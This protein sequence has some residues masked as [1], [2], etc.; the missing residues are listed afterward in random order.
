MPER[1][2]KMIMETG[3]TEKVG[4]SHHKIL[5]DI[6]IDAAPDIVW[7]VLTDTANY[8]DWAA[9]LVA[10]EGQIEDGATITAVFHTDPAKDNLTRIDHKITVLDGEAFY[11]AE[12]GPG[13][14][15]DNHHFRVE[16]NED[17]QTRFTQSDEIM[18]G[19]TFL[20]GGRLAKMYLDGY[21]AFTHGL[22]A[23]AEKQARAGQPAKD[24]Q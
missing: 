15:R 6:I 22:K 3:R 23:E 12:K 10:I 19:V 8:R 13:G 20:M 11:W 21:Q 9:F 17:G 18:G 2:E 16:A 4:F 1:L 5:T 14:I 24:A 7:A